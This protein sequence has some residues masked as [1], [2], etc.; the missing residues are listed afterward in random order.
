LPRASRA[1]EEIKSAFSGAS[2]ELI[3]SSGGVFDVH[4]DGKRIFSK[5]EGG[6]DQF[7]RFPEPGELIALINQ[8]LV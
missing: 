1:E 2:V 6:P 7:K 3:A 8:N 4:L 5:K